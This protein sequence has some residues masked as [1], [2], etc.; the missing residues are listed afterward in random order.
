MP[1]LK[2]CDGQTI[3]TAQE[4]FEIAN[5]TEHKRSGKRIR[6]NPEHPQWHTSPSMEEKFLALQTVRA[7][8]YKFCE[9]HPGPDQ[10]YWPANKDWRPGRIIMP[11]EPDHEPVIADWEWVPDAVGP[12]DI[13][14]IPL[15]YGSLEGP[16]PET[17][18]Q[19]RLPDYGKFLAMIEELAPRVKGIL[20]G[21]N[22]CELTH[23]VG[24]RIKG[25]EGEDDKIGISLPESIHQSC[26]FVEEVAPLVLQAGGRPFFGT[27]DWTI[28]FDCYSPLLAGRLRQ[29]VNAV[30]GVHICLCAATLVADGNYDRNNKLLAR[31]QE[32]VIRAEEEDANDPKRLRAYLNAGTF[33]G[34]V[35]GP[36]NIHSNG[37]RLKDL[38]FKELTV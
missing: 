6:Y 25:A 13:V 9:W 19:H 27:M 16:T 14:W 8:V 15:Y 28:L 26:A 29:I 2:L 11:V 7:P 12:N 24:T 31:G 36:K 4:A 30:N 37:M 38:G 5:S 23:R 10:I 18:P 34:D 20:L 17:W 33:W 22:G 35:E 1:E 21:N 3:S 32:Q